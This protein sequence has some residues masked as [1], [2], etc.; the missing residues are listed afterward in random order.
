MPSSNTQTAAALFDDSL[1]Q[2]QEFLADI[3]NG[4]SQPDKTLPC[5]YFYD[6]QGSRLFEAICETPE[7]YVTRT[8]IDI[9]SH[10]MAAIAELVGPETDILEFGSGAGT[11]IQLLLNGLH[12]P[13]SYI[14][15]DISMEILE[16]SAQKLTALFPQVQVFPIVGDYHK[17]IVLPQSFHQPGQ[18]RKLV[19]F[20][21]STIS[22]FTPE[23]AGAFLQRIRK[24]LSTD[25][26]LLIG[27]DC[28]KPHHILNAAYND[29]AGHTAAF[30]LNLLQRIKNT[31]DTNLKPQHFFHHAYFNETQSR[32]EMHLVSKQDQLIEIEGNPIK[33][34][35][36][37]TIHTENSYKYTL[38]GFKKMAADSD[39]ETT[40]VWQDANQLFSLHY[41]TAR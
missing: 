10:N 17:E 18:H 32:I 31:F 24:L 28:V 38:P 15:I 35:K 21:G 5:K 26:A 16:L 11:K 7:Y 8:E 9:L 4:L 3:L 2:E 23:E 12:A 29:Q 27:V 14:P 20:P 33:F 1:P 6:E 39:F 19:F 37:E 30:N 41:L 36:G 22:N 25:D 40:Q 13:R 34:R